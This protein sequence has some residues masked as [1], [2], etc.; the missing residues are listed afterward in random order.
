M[1]VASCVLGNLSRG[2]PLTATL[3]NA[4]GPVKQRLFPLMKQ[5][6]MELRSGRQFRQRAFALDPHAW[7]AATF[8]AIVKGPRQRQSD[9]FLP[10]NYA[11]KV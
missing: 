6:R 5:G 1:Q 3:E 10:W 4:R 9:D 7:L 8:V 11:A 2:C